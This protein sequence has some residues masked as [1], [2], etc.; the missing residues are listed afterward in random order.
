[1]ELIKKFITVTGVLI[2]TGVS[3]PLIGCETIQKHPDLAGT[4]GGAGA[5]YVIGGKKGA[6][7]GGAAGYVIGD[8]VQDEQRDKELRELRERQERLEREQLPRDFRY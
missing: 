1:M 5:G 6:V 8:K 7:I 3:L 4:I 2:A